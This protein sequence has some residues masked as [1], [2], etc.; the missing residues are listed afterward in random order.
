[1]KRSMILIFSVITLAVGFAFLVGNSNA[2]RSTAQTLTIP[3]TVALGKDA[4][5]GPI[6]FN[7]ADH[8]TKNYNL[9]GDG[10]IQCTECHHTAQPTSEVTKHALWKTSWPSGRT[11]SLTKE[12]FTK[13]AATA[14]AAPCR[15]CHVKTGETP[16]L[17]PKLPEVTLPAAETPTVV[18]NMVAFHRRCTACHME[19]QK[20]RP[21]AK[22]PTASQCMLC[23]KK[24]A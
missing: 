23:H 14:G 7:H 21:T 9:A 1:M 3:D 5:L 4:K 16:K 10:P 2:F 17:L 6:T 11:T 12:L 13:D 20:L 22:G 18:T 24:T 8:V 15:S 19:V